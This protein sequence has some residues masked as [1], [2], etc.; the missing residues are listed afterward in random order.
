MRASITGDLYQT[1]LELLIVELGVSNDL[2]YIPF[3]RMKALAT[4]SLIKSTWELIHL[5]NIQLLHT[6]KL[7][8]HWVHDKPIME[9]LP[10]AQ[11]E[12]EQ[13]LAF[14]RCRLYLQAFFLSDIVDGCGT[15]I[16]EDAC[17]GRPNVCPETLPSW[18]SQGM[19]TPSDWSTWRLLLR[20]RVLMRGMKIKHT[21]GHWIS[22]QKGSW[23]YSPSLHSMLHK[24][25]NSWLAHPYVP[26][27][28]GKKQFQVQGRPVL[29]VP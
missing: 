9:F 3:Q 10:I 8:S 2:H 24:S 16:T 13:L 12:L 14:N 20:K 1:S 29:T 6:I 22:C 21:L 15:S 11:L 19:P 27:R 5:N 23:F 18:P 17:M 4:P 26:N 7:T 28:F 25:L